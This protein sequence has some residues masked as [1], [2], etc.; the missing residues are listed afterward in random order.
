MPYHAGVRPPANVQRWPLVVVLLTAAFLR[1]SFS[2]PGAWQEPWTPHHFDEHILPYEALA[3]WEGVTPREVGWPA[4]TYRV[5]LSLAYSIP[6]LADSGAAVAHSPTPAAAMHVVAQWSGARVGDPHILYMLGRVTSAVIGIVQVLATFMMARAW[7]G[8]VGGVFGAALAAVSPLA[9]THSQLL[10]ADVTGALFSTMMLGLLPRAWAGDG[11]VAPLLGFLVGLAAASKFH[12]G[13][14]LLPALGVWWVSRPDGQATA[15]RTVSSLT[16]LVVCAF[17][18]V[19]LVPWLW[20]N[21]VLG[22]KEFAGVVLAKAGAGAGAGQFFANMQSILRG[23]GWGILI[24]VVPGAWL[25]IRQRGRP[26]V[27]VLG[28]VALMLALVS[29]SSTVFDRYGLIA[30]PG[31]TLAAAAAWSQLA[32]RLQTSVNPATVAVVLLLLF[33][34]QPV[35]AV[36][37]LGQINT[38]HVAHAWLRAHL[39]SGASVVIYSEDNQYLPRTSSQLVACANAVWTP[40]AYRDKWATNGIASSA[41]SVM[42]MRLAVL[43]D[44]LFHSHWC[45][46]EL[47]AERAVAFDVYRFHFQPRYAT[48]PFDALKQEFS[49][50]ASDPAR[51]FDAVLVHVPLGTAAEPSRTFE[52]VTGPPL[53][54]YL[55]PGLALRGITA[56]SSSQK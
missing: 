30:F 40:A 7:L 9:V 22:L 23:L 25:L 33:L 52:T 10:L 18:I 46:R 32:G 12:F 29:V 26:A 54:L 15:G 56:V 8:N 21:P 43:N 39:P 50:G 37:R 14:W 35:A 28:T 31:L 49:A 41:E 2:I 16:V 55:R 27:L 51:G 17:T 24:G 45:E 19:A 4:S 44:E 36:S 5:L 47:A 53:L 3:L 6:F 42:P 34:P 11:R 20:I 48:I 1:L 13:I 38:Y